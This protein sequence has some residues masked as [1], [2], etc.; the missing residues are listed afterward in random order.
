MYVLAH[1]LLHLGLEHFPVREGRKAWNVA[2]DCYIARFLY[3]LKIGK[4][5]SDM[6][7]PLHL[8]NQSEEK[9]MRACCGTESNR[10]CFHSARQATIPT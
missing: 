1:C 5:P 2:C 3:D 8:T 9:Y 6:G 10:N 4:A 7:N